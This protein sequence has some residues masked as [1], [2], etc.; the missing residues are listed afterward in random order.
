M[1]TKK[2]V[3]LFTLLFCIEKIFADEFITDWKGKN[4]GSEALPSYVESLF[5]NDNPKKII[6]KFNLNKNDLLFYDSETAMGKEIA[7]GTA[8]LK[9]K[10]MA[11]EAIKKASGEEELVL[12]VVNLKKVYESWIKIEGDNGS[13]YKAYSVYKLSKSD[14]DDNVE[15]AKL[16]REKFNAELE[17]AK[18]LEKNL[19]SK[20]EMELEEEVNSILD[21]IEIS[22][23]E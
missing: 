11:G 7:E 4:T 2:F 1:K 12:N 6:K 18:K 9:V 16:A 13:Y 3:I 20:N 15:L 21:E 22:V 10:G 5:E 17:E 14:F 19:Q 23:E 8:R